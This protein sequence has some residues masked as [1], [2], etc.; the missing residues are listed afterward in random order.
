MKMDEEISLIEYFQAIKKQWLVVILIIV[1]FSLGGLLL[2]W[3]FPTVYRAESVILPIES[4]GMSLGGGMGMLAQM[5]GIS[6]PTGT[7]TIAKKIELYLKSKVFAKRM[8][9]RHHLD[10]VF[11]LYKNEKQKEL[12]ESKSSEEKLQMTAKELI[13][14]IKVIPN[15]S[16]GTLQIVVESYGP[17]LAA[18]LNGKILTELE[19]FLNDEEITNARKKRVFIGQQLLLNEK[20]LLKTGKSLAHFNKINRVSEVSSTVDVT[21][22]LVSSGI[23]SSMELLDDDAKDNGMKNESVE[24]E[25]VENVPQQTYL[26]HSLLRK[27]I[28][29]TVQTMLYQQYEMAK[30]DEKKEN[31]TFQIIDEVEVPG[32]PYTAKQ[33]IVIFGSVVVGFFMA[34]LY[35]F[36][37]QYLF[38]IRRATI[39]EVKKNAA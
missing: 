10:K 24:G 21:L 26:E 17:K 35:A 33:R 27:E 13:K 3:R 29:G 16:F 36:I 14:M 5:V 18:D 39:M 19:G 1:A 28:L 30:I 20:E 11:L 22:R 34:L 38:K 25:I 15:E 6:S 7:V 12:F 31:T 23:A 4:Q 8:V 37:Q 2:S 32:A 9:E